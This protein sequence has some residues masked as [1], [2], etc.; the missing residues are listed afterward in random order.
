[1]NRQDAKDYIR[2]QEPFFLEKAKRTG[3][4]CPYCGN[5]SG[6]NGDGIVKDAKDPSKTHYKCFVCG[7]YVDIIDL[8][9][10]YYGIDSNDWASKFSK[11]FEVYGIDPQN[12]DF[13]H[14]DR[15]GQN[16]AITPR[17]TQSRNLT[18]L[19]FSRKRPLQ[20]P[21]STLLG[22]VFQKVHKGGF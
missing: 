6:A 19:L 10:Q 16:K 17:L 5:G 3:W 4:I 7:Q 15:N 18:T 1:M 13:I 21:L 20:I 9:G 22:G 14:T 11:A 2:Q 8:V 12:D